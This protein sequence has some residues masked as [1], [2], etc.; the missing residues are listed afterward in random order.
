MTEK[1]S[2]SSLKVVKSYPV[3]FARTLMDAKAAFK[4]SEIQFKETV[5][6]QL[7][8]PIPTI[9]RWLRAGS[10]LVKHP[11]LYDVLKD[12]KGTGRLLEKIS[13][14]GLSIESIN[15]IVKSAGFATQATST[16]PAVIDVGERLKALV[17]EG[18][19]SINFFTGVVG[20]PDTFLIPLRPICYSLGLD[21]EGQC[22]KVTNSPWGEGKILS[23]GAAGP[24]IDARI[25][26]MWIATVDPRQV[27]REEDLVNYQTAGVAA[28]F[29]AFRKTTAPATLA[30]E[31][32]A[33]LARIE[34]KIET[35][36]GAN[37]PVTSGNYAFL[38]RLEDRGKSA[39]GIANEFRQANPGEMVSMDDVKAIAVGLGLVDDP[40][41]GQWC[42]MATEA[43]GEM[44][45]RHWRFNEAGEK[46]VVSF[47]EY[48]MARAE[49]LIT[50]GTCRTR[51]D[52]ISHLLKSPDVHRIG[53]GRHT[54]LQKEFPRTQHVSAN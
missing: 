49:P 53:V 19:S 47:L 18:R 23:V 3:K 48:Y 8:M 32:A 36:R 42:V 9:N 6:D 45:N 10:V 54:S 26:P 4:G 44:T 50:D 41:F 40:D 28:I 25:F 52:V 51:F 37:L 14:K 24:H 11:E 43:H 1:F 31:V 29:D 7:G 22:R 33:H 30:P 16:A 21:I 17:G 20:K 38:K 13:I 39:T 34:D 15:K 35:L 5:K 12:T 27:V 2:V 46:H